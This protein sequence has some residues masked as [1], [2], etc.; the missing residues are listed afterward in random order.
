MKTTTFLKD[1]RETRGDENA[2]LANFIINFARAAFLM[3][4]I[5]P[6]FKDRE[7]VMQEAI[8]N[9]VVSIA[10]CLET[11]YRDISIYVLSLDE[12]I[13][14]RVL[15][16]LKTKTTYADIHSLLK[17]GIKFSEIAATE[18]SFQS[19][20]EI[21]SF[22]S[23]LFHPKG[24]FEELDSYSLD[25]LVP[26]RSKRVKMQLSNQWRSEYASIFNHRHSLVH[27]ANK[28]CLIQLPEIQ[29]LEALALTVPQMTAELIAQK[30]P[31]KGTIRANG[32]P[33]LLLVEDVISEDWEIANDGFAI[34]VEK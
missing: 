31:I 10:S 11:F 16:D 8:K 14:E 4:K 21:D 1:L 23:K 26:T 2:Y 24:Y 27:N 18:A 12:S 22:M 13:L 28:P 29:K 33:V 17:D 19:M 20:A 7:V 34:R 25:C 32:F 15:P 30:F 9:Y 5:L 6:Q 3:H